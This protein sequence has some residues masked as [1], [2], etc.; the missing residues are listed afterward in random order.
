[1]YVAC[2]T[3]CFARHPLDRALHLIDE[4]G[5]SKVEIAIDS[6][7]PHVRPADA[8]AD[9]VGV[10][11][12]LRIGP[13][14]TPAAFTVDIQAGDDTDYLRQFKAV[15]E[16]ARIAQVP[17][18]AIP[19]APSGSDIDT[20]VR[21]LKA[22]IKMTLTEGLVLTLETRLGTMTELPD[23]AV[24]LC[25]RVSGLGLTLDPSHFLAGPNQGKP[26][27]QVYP[28]VSHVHLRDS[29]RASGQFQVRV[30]QGEVEYGRVIGQLA[31]HKYNRL[32]TVEIYDMPD[33]P[34]PMD[35]E[36]RKLKYLL[37]SMI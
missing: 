28:F 14:L 18:L 7:G 33:S 26:F 22:L 29:G 4:M 8:I 31:R 12:R 20:E 1:M 5:F 10:A 3:V 23:V 13:S 32:L 15:C 24:Q 27:D 11:Q 19:A 16:L 2:S 35:Q 25:E 6:N 34:Y 9:A 17:L 30:G 36:V 37:E 21:R